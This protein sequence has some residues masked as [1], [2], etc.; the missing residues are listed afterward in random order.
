MGLPPAETSSVVYYAYDVKIDGKNV[1]TLQNF[2]PTSNRALERIREIAHSA[3]D[4]IEITPGR[5][6]SSITIEK[7]ELYNK[8]LIEALGY[9]PSGVADLESSFDIIEVMHRPDGTKRTI[10]YDRCWVETYGKTVNLTTISVTENVTVQVT[11]I[12]IKPE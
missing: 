12:I 11:N 8:S 9:D 5:T 4:T 2:S 7:L 3:V 10:I 6:D 1:G